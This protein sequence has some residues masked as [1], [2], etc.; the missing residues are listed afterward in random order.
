MKNYIVS[1]LAGLLASSGIAATL[2][3]VTVV[4]QTLPTANSRFFIYPQ[5]FLQAD[6]FTEPGQAALAG[7]A[8]IWLAQSQSQTAAVFST[9]T[10]EARV[11]FVVPNDYE[12]GLRAWAYATHSTVTNTVTL[13]VDAAV[14]KLNALTSTSTVFVGTTTNVQVDRFNGYSMLYDSRMSRFSLPIKPVLLT[15]TAHVS[16]G[17]LV[18]LE[19]ERTAGTDGNLSIYA[20]EIEYNAK[21]G[22][23]P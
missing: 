18:N 22:I 11:N 12:K 17:S 20:I 6:G 19:I 2:S 4:A 15:Y 7:A 23:K 9:G 16:P 13:R 3:S 1:L 14:I 5:A 8:T 21:Q 10:S